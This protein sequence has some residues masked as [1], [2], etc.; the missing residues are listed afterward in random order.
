MSDTRLKTI[1]KAM[2]NAERVQLVRCLAQE[3]SV[4]GLLQKCD[5]SQSA[6]S[7]HLAVLRAAGIIR[8]RREGRKIYYSTSSE[9]VKLAGLIITL[10]E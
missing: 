9:W 10:T 7:Q 3:V 6:L 2:G 4:N 8:S 5:L 1:C